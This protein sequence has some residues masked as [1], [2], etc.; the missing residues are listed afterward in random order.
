VADVVKR[1]K[2]ALADRYRIELALGGRGTMIVF[3]RACVSRAESPRSAALG[4]MRVLKDALLGRARP[5]RAGLP[6]LV[7]ELPC[8]TPRPFIAVV[9]HTDIRQAAKSKVW[10][11]QAKLGLLRPAKPSTSLCHPAPLRRHQRVSHSVFSG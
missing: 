2:A 6:T 8:L 10:T 1:L 5:I 4:G 9:E 11:L 7:V 3:G